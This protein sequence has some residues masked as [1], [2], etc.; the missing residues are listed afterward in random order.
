MSHY[1]EEAKPTILLVRSSA[2]F[3]L[4]NVITA[5]LLLCVALPNPLLNV[6]WL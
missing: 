2:I 3:S 1:L 6:L 4:S 5:N